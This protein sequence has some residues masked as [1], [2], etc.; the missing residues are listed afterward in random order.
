GWLVKPG[1]AEAWAGVLQ[2]AIALGPQ[3]RARM[4]AAAAERARRLYS[5]EAMCAATLAVYARVLVIKLG[6]L[7][8]FVQALRAMAEIRRAHPKASITLLTT[9]PYAELADASGW[10]DAI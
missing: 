5:V 4:G 2:A 6:A 9:P 7:G 1:D 10:F 3:A 8:D